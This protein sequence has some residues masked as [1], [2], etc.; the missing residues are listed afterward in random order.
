MELILHDIATCD[1]K[2]SR[3]DTMSL[4][5]TLSNPSGVLAPR[6]SSTSVP[7]QS[8]TPFQFLK[9]PRGIRDMVRM[10]LEEVYIWNIA[11]FVNRDFRSMTK[12]SELK[13]LSTSSWRR[14][15]SDH[16]VFVRTRCFTSY[17]SPT[18]TGCCVPSCSSTRSLPLLWTSYF[19]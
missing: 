15:H 3:F 2:P 18:E 11:D 19:V 8:S 13:S 12:C 17:E 16:L 10:P 7:P 4:S 6:S 9:L 5:N 14:S 1:H